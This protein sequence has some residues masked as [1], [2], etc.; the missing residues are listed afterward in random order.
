MIIECG[1]ITNNKVGIII[2][3]RCGIIIGMENDSRGY[4]LPTGPVWL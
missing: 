1:M 4:R 2:N 3:D